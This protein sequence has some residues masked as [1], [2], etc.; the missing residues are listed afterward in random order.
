MDPIAKSRIEEDL[1][2][3]LEGDLWTD[4]VHLQL[5]ASDASIY[6]IRPS[7]VV[8]PNSTADVVACVQ[9]A[10]ENELPI[11]ARG[12]GTGLAG[13]SLGNGILIDF[14]YYMRRAI[15]INETTARIQPGMVLGQLNN[16]LKKRQRHFGPDP[17]TRSVTT[18]GSVAA[19]NASGS[20]WM[21]YGCARDKIRSLQMVLANGEVIETG[22]LPINPGLSSSNPSSPLKQIVR[23]L[24]DLLSK[25][26]NLIESMRPKTAVSR[27][28]YH[29][30][31]L[32]ENYH[33]N[34][35]KLIVGSEGTLGLITEI[36]VDTDLRPTHRG[37]T[38]LFFNRLENAA[39]ASIEISGMGATA[40]DLM[41]R[42]L[43]SIARETDSRFE[44]LIPAIAEA[45][46]IVE[47]DGDEIHHVRER[48]QHVVAVIQ[49]EKRLAFDS[50][51]TLDTSERNFYWRLSRRVIPRLYRLAG[52]ERP[53]PFLEDIA[54]PPQELP[55]FVGKMQRIL[56]KHEITASLF[57]H[58]GHGQLH[59]RPFL[60]ISNDEHVRKMHGLAS[61]LYEE[62]RNC[63]GT[64]S[65][66]H[67]DGLSRTWFLRRQF[68]DLYPVFQEI[69]KIFD[70]K[71]ILN[72][73]KIV[74][75][76]PQPLSK[77]L[78]SVTTGSFKKWNDRTESAIAEE[79]KRFTKV[80]VGSAEKELSE[81]PAD[82]EALYSILDPSL[83][84]TVDEVSAAARGCNGCGRCRTTMDDER[85]C[86]IFRL[87]PGEEASPRA[88]AN[89]M[90]AIMTGQLEPETL[91][92]DE[93]KKIADL[94]VNCHQCRIECPASVDIPKLMA[95]AKS[96]HY[97]LTGLS[98]N[99][100]LINRID[101]ICAFGS[102]F[103]LISNWATGN[104]TARWIIEKIF[105]IAQGRKLPR[106]SSRNFLRGAQKK[107]LTKP[108]RKPGRKVVYFVDL[109]ANWIDVQLAEAFINVM[110]HNGVEVFVPPDQQFSGL[111][112][113]SN[114]M[115]DNARKIANR[116]VKVLVEAVRQGYQVV[117][118]EPGAALC[119][120]HEYLNYLDDEDA[121]RVAENSIDACNFLWQ[122]HT[123][124][125]LE[126]DF[127]PLNLVF[128][129][130]LPCHQKALQLGA[131]GEK[132][133]SLIPGIKVDRISKGCS[134]MA[135]NYG[136]SKKNFRRSLR[137]GR[138]LINEIRKPVFFAGTT[139]CSACK[140]QMEQGT[141]KPTIHPIKILAYAYGVMP[142]LESLFSTRSDSRF[143]S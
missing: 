78:R 57:A 135:G 32:I 139:E 118:T 82:E 23:K 64:I 100:W 54:V 111:S 98:F 87:E 67:G 53:V 45:A 96:Q 60:D 91:G 71:G 20:H 22:K 97:L 27:S 124:G 114:G 109:Y 132:L 1:K 88:K 102:R 117:T 24:S 68:G 105:G 143:V 13:E 15:A 108:T 137:I 90:R 104:N 106:F 19:L 95:E 28:G 52:N 81:E 25:H 130:H 123:Q 9:Y 120:R 56:Q 92:Q 37:V 4:D 30:Y 14:S 73:D 11:I 43:L 63:H 140:M 46:L 93:F 62:V 99:E 16:Q 17:A 115:T 41:D 77:N 33:L 3:V 58:A 127:N 8:R 94:C 129:Y 110:Q 47:F 74:A 39:Q 133:L 55:S 34:L 18:M 72:P 75:E 12:A 7:C 80:T 83:T 6:E 59:I 128:G 10:N 138:D 36:E 29:V 103:R 112:F 50:R 69:K 107:Q 51:M 48:L 121:K 38:I 49:R 89:L 119:L 126:L 122:M 2:G 79:E 42:R 113:I 61:E 125:D 134:G 65:G 5:Y 84:W 142:E 86:P 66:E 141:N 76:L 31:D 136:L 44:M 131:D 70:P 21:K 101:W 85:M 116:N 26:K 40:C 35:T